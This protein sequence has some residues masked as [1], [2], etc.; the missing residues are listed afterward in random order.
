MFCVT[1]RLGRRG[2][3]RKGRGGEVRGNGGTFCK[4]TATLTAAAGSSEVAN[5]LISRRASSL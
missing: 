3:R 5:S 2:R 4:V 1:A